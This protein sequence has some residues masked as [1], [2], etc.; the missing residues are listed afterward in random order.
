MAYGASNS[1]VTDDVTWLWKVNS[2]LQ[3]STRPIARHH[4]SPLSTLLYW[5]I[6]THLAYHVPRQPWPAVHSC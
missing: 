2:W 6:S 4:T 1:Y 3:Y 5:Q